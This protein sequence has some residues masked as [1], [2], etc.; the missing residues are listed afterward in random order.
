MIRLRAALG[1]A[2]LVPACVPGEQEPFRD[3]GLGTW[4]EMAG[5]PELAYQASAIEACDADGCALERVVARKP[6]SLRAIWGDGDATV[7]AVGDGLILER[8][9]PMAT[10]PASIG[11]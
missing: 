11:R 5:A 1:A 4:V 9:L 7:I 8:T 3:K 10:P 6:A 2:L